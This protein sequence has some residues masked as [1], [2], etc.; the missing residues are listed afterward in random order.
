MAFLV[1][2]CA[3]L[4]LDNVSARFTELDYFAFLYWDDNPAE[5]VSVD[6]EARVRTSFLT[7]WKADSPPLV[8][9]SILVRLAYSLQLA[10]E[11]D[12]PTHS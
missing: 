6:D 4:G 10:A 1:M 3:R 2:I 5:G 7:E 11:A 12:S 8:P 9:V